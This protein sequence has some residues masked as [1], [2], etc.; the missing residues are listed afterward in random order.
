MT[1]SLN[2]AAAPRAQSPRLLDQVR[3]EA[4][5]EFARPEPAQ[6]YVQWCTAY[7]LFHGK[8]HPREMSRAEAGRFLTHVVQSEKDPLGCLEAAREA[9][10]F[11]YD[12]VLH[13]PLGEL[14]YPE[15]PKLLDRL[16][17]AIRLRHSSP[18]TEAYYA[19]WAERF[20][21][22]HGLRHPNTMGAAEIEMFLTDLAVNASLLPSENVPSFQS[23]ARKP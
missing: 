17:W 16:R 22:F 23:A 4:L 12:E 1:A 14:P 9:L 15:P 21:R 3:D 20:I 5:Q 19:D 10:E 13:A 2:G 7:I 8:R 6:R 11:L 18:R